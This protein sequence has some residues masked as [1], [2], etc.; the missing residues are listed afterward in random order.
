MTIDNKFI[1][2]KDSD[3]EFIFTIKQNNSTLPVIIENTDT[4]LLKLYNLKSNSKVAEITMADNQNTGIIEVFDAANGQ[5]KVRFYEALVSTLDSERGS[6]ADRYYT[7]PTY[8]LIID[9]NTVH[10]GIFN[11]KIDLVYVR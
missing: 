8:R 2:N 5:I 4:F 1:I 10:N 6:K 7:K 11:A 3:N 9:C